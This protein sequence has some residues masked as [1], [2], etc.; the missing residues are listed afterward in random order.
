[1][2]PSSHKSPF[3]SRLVSGSWFEFFVPYKAVL[4]HAYSLHPS[5]S[6]SPPSSV[7]V[8]AASF[9]L[10]R[11]FFLKPRRPASQQATPR[12][13]NLDPG[14]IAGGSRINVRPTSARAS[15]STRPVAGG[16]GSQFR[17]PH[18]AVRRPLSQPDSRNRTPELSTARKVTRSVAYFPA[19]PSPK[20][21]RHG[22]TWRSFSRREHLIEFFYTGDKA[23]FRTDI[24]NLVRQ[25]LVEMKSSP[26]GP[27]RF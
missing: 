10:I 24:E 4:F 20:W 2:R 9:V 8:F 25:G 18:I 7:N 1:M 5:F 13:R 14:T 11:K 21:R 26:R 19:S 23:R 16:N 17:P 15:R 27:C 6:T 12:R 3:S 22:R